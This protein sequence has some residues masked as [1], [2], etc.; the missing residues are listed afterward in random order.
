MYLSGISCCLLTAS[1]SLSPIPYPLTHTP[2]QTH[3][4]LP[5][6]SFSEPIHHE[7]FVLMTIGKTSSRVKKEEKRCR[8]REMEGEKI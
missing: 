3:Q 4:I 8:V 2:V 5:Q 1:L 7:K 6:A